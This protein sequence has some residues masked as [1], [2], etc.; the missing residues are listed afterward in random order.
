MQPLYK[1]ESA[2]ND[3]RTQEMYGSKCLM[4]LHPRTMA[5]QRTERTGGEEQVGFRITVV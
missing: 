5:N 2:T 4:N 1:K 3:K